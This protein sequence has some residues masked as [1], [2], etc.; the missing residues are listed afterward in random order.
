MS[1]PIQPSS[2]PNK[3]LMDPRSTG[4]TRAVRVADILALRGTLKTPS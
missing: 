4:A 1:R 2:V 3:G